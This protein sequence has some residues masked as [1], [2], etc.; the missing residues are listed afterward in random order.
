[1]YENQNPFLLYYTVSPYLI[2]TGVSLQ[3]S[4]F[5]GGKK[6]FF[7]H[8]VSSCADFNLGYLWTDVKG[9]VCMQIRMVF[10]LGLFN[11]DV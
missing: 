5:V 11:I 6:Q 3:M 7:S 2:S 1:M 9:L 8:S 10:S 4:K